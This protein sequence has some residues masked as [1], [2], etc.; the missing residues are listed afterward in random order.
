MRLAHRPGA[1]PY[2]RR[3][4]PWRRPIHVDVA[5]VEKAFYGSWRLPIAAL[6][7]GT[8]P[9]GLPL[10]TALKSDFLKSQAGCNMQSIATRER[11]PSP[12]RDIDISGI[13]L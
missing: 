9:R 8:D 11:L 6:V 10:A 2:G 5:A 12:D 7:D 3:R 13:D 1:Q 4:S